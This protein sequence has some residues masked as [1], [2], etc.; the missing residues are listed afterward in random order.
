MPKEFKAT[1]AIRFYEC[2]SYGHMN[3]ANYL[4]LMQEAA[5]RASTALGYDRRKYLAM[6]SLWVVRETLIEYLAPILYDEDV[7]I[8]TWVS[9]MH[10][11]RSLRNYVFTKYSDGVIA[12]KG[13]TDW[14]YVSYPE[15][16]LTK[17][18]EEIRQIYF[19]AGEEVPRLPRVPFPALPEEAPKVYTTSKRVEW[20]D[21][22]PNG[23]VHNAVYLAYLED[24][25]MQV[26]DH[27]GWTLDR[28][29]AEGLRILV[30][31]HHIQ[32][33]KPAFLDDILTIDTWI[34]DLKSASCVR[35]YRIRRESDGEDV[36][37]CHSK[38][39]W[40]DHASGKPVR[41]PADFMADFAE[42][43]SQT[44]KG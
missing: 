2:D 25:G 20:R 38:Y 37:Y 5:F 8:K 28:L 39:V 31:Q 35:H 6:G 30:K 9:D 23:H 17:I 15:F 14:V 43:T 33:L 13:W 12:A 16:F 44:K 4:R 1:F 22:D 36:L 34:S 18:P 42:N 32:Y 21:L 26:A 11:V 29:E 19:E 10:R 27:Y 40:V 41:I 3:N 7:E 24:C